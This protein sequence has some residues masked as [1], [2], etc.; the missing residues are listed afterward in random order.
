MSFKK[1]FSLRRKI[2]ILLALILVAAFSVS[3]VLLNNRHEQEVRRNAEEK[4]RLKVREVVDRIILENAD[5]QQRMAASLRL[6]SYFLKQEGHITQETDSI[7]RQAI[8]YE[9]GV[10]DF[11]RLPVWTVNGKDI[12]VLQTIIDDVYRLTGIESAVFQ[13]M[14]EGYIIVAQGFGTNFK[15]RMSDFYIPNSS[16]IIPAVENGEIHT[17]TFDISGRKYEA[18]FFP[19]FINSKIN[20]MIAC[21][22]QYGITRETSDKIVHSSIGV[23]GRMFAVGPDNGIFIHPESDNIDAVHVSSV[24][25]HILPAQNKKGIYEEV[26]KSDNGM[27]CQKVAFIPDIN[28]YVGIMCPEEELYDD[29]SNYVFF[30]VMILVVVFSV[31]YFV[32]VF[33]IHTAFVAFKSIRQTLI[34]TSKGEFNEKSEYGFISKFRDIASIESITSNMTVQKCVRM[35]CINDILNDNYDKDFTSLN[36]ADKESDLLKKLREKLSHRFNEDI[37]T[38]EENR[39]A[40]WINQGLTKFIDILR[41]HGQGRS[42]LAYNIISNLVDYVKA[43]QGAIYFTDDDVEGGTFF[44]MAA[45][46]AYEQQRIINKRIPIDEGLLGRA[47]HESRII[48]ITELPS[49]YI[50]IVSGLGEAPPSNLI[51]VP[52]IFNRKISGMLE[53]ASFNNFK[54][55]EVTFLERIAESIA[56]A[57][58]GLKIN[59]RTEN[60]LQ[61]SQEQSKLM[62]IQEVE[63]RKNLSE[64]RRLR[65]ETETKEMEMKGLFRAIDA[66]SLVIEYD[67]E[68]VILHVN[69][70]VTDL[71]QIP[72]EELIGKNH[73]DISSFTPENKEYKKF[74]DDLRSG[75]T[76]SLVESV[77]TKQKVFW[78]SETFSP[79]LDEKG[80]VVKIIDIGIDVSET[81]VLE[82]QLRLQE[83]EINKQ[84]DK[85]NEKEKEIAEKQRIIDKHELESGQIESALDSCIVIIEFNRRGIILSA[86]KKTEEITGLTTDNIINRDLSE[87][88]V[89]ETVSSFES[90][91]MLLTT[92]RQNRDILKFAGKK[93]VVVT[94]QADEFP[95]V[96]DKGDIEKILLIGS[97]INN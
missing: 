81:K 20:G 5:S 86:N 87:L 64:M 97:I 78:L 53:I 39:N 3:C 83:R 89:P 26:Y 6:F 28:I 63:M 48:N 12:S 47:Y 34:H 33:I 4:M 19:L 17:G 93:G 7:E 56:S 18:S 15:T 35:D 22:R 9:T 70:K 84:L 40:E 31:I 44:D 74:W 73:T 37:K 50:H 82:R 76:R 94:I 30:L 69:T 68:G 43:N 92:R 60:L 58:S 1:Y 54:S 42:V 27:I 24:M 52:L 46:Y 51:I 23:S 13:K 2:N 77:A 57:I 10:T 72:E 75:S 62:K 38:K 65:T 29:E 32:F 80:D 49:D 14:P 91:L 59:E 71:F 25:Q 45:C 96:N 90:T 55:Y 21:M 67:K 36:C 66:T 11:R 16:E 79:V 8:D 41:F 61:Q 85:M 95:I 88:L